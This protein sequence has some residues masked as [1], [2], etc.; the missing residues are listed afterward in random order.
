M[1]KTFK[2]LETKVI[3]SGEPDPLIN[4]SVIMPIFQTAMFEHR[5]GGNY[6]DIRYIRLNNTPNHVALHE[7]LSA[8]E[9]A[10]AALV[11]ASGMA[12]VTH[13]SPLGSFIGRPRIGPGVPVWWHA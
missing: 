12:A 11:M 1:V 6:H 3:H 10:E 13:N 2:H 7:K 4:G 8:L 5:G 9:G